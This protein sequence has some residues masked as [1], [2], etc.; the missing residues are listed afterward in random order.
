MSDQFVRISQ[1]PECTK[2]SITDYLVIENSED[3]WK[4]KFDVFTEYINS[5]VQT[6]VDGDISS[7]LDNKI[8]EIQ[9]QIGSIDDLIRQLNEKIVEFDRAEERRNQLEKDIAQNE[10]IRQETYDE[11]RVMI[12][13]WIEDEKDRKEYHDTVKREWE[14]MN[15]IWNDWSNTEEQRVATEDERKQAELN[16]ASAESEREKKADEMF[17][18]GEI[19]ETNE[20][21]RVISFNNMTNDFSD[22]IDDFNGITDDFNN[23]T[24]YFNNIK[25]C[26]DNYVYEGTSNVDTDKVVDILKV[27][28]PREN[29]GYEALLHLKCG[30]MHTFIAL[31]FSFSYLNQGISGGTSKIIIPKKYAE[32]LNVANEL[33][34]GWDG[35]DDNLIEVVL[36]Y[37]CSTAGSVKTAIIWDNITTY[38]PNDTDFIYAK[39]LKEQEQFDSFSTTRTFLSMSS[40]NDAIDDAPQGFI[41][42]LDSLETQIGS[43]IDEIK[44]Y[45]MY[46]I[47]SIYMTVSSQSPEYIL[48]G[49]TWKA[50]YDRN[51]ISEG[52]TREDGLA[53]YSPAIYYWERTA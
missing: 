29:H 28:L 38:K 18:K 40:S 48:G 5:L 53:L 37:K 3:T 34:I 12:D 24:G 31:N 7:T 9:L 1:L 42:I 30:E 22:M 23:M 19:A 16:R 50:L 20:A 33:C 39:A 6:K 25:S 49:G 36:Q 35:I 26:L 14:G 10:A 15:D 43:M 47:G 44:P 17:K 2:I 52:L 27:V 11:N 8:S 41:D 32:Q 13:Q 4:V 21:N 45:K 46:P 51:G